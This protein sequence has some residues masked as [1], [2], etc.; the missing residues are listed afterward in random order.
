MKEL[1]INANVITV[2]DDNPRAEAFV[3]EDGMFVFVGS[4]E[5]AEN[6]AG[7]DCRVTD[8]KGLT[9]VPGFNDS[10]MHLLN[11]A[12]HR[13]K[14]NLYGTSS[15]DEIIDI[16][17]RWINERKP[18]DGQWILAAGWN[19]YD[20]K[21]G[22]ML[23][24][25]D[26]DKICSDKPMLFTRCCE[27][28]V[29]VN[30]KAMEI[31]G[32]TDETPDPESGIIERDEEGHATGILKEG[33]RYLAYGQ[34]PDKSVEE[35]KEMLIDGMSYLSSCGVTSVQ[36]DDFETFSSKNWRN[37]IQAYK[38]L[39]AEGKMTVRVYEQCLLPEM[40][41]FNEFLQAGYKTG[42]G[43]DVFKIG[44][45]KLLC[46][47]SLGPRTSYLR[48]DYSDDPGNRGINVFEQDELNELCLTAHKNG[49][50]VVCHAIGDAT[51]DM[52]LTAFEYAQ[53]NCPIKDHRDGIIHVQ[54]SPKDI[55]DRMLKDNVISYVQPIFVNSDLHMADGRLGER[56]KDAYKFR[57]MNEI[58]LRV[59]LSSDCPVESCNPID[60][61][62]VA[63]T[64]KDL[65]GYPEGGWHTEEALTIEQ[66]IKGFTI[67]G[68]YAQF[69]ENIK[70]SIE[71]DKYADF[72]VLTKDITQV[73]PEDILTIKAA[74]TY[75]GGSCVYTLD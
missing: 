10:H 47:G 25:S 7:E 65:N 72:V 44:P 38:E 63:V 51:C 2:D 46:D 75:M 37:V 55:L 64:R 11:F 41:R 26:L 6:A 74:A 40:G 3:V 66:V 56:V 52:V 28:T 69:M 29:C 50:H 67:D 68:A 70:G 43:S 60:S 35:I 23:N 45:L 18:A 22:R 16:S 33:A 9:V 39:E 62:Y 30:S 71:Q 19:H 34:L 24:A 13:T 57:T 59:P 61:A 14:I 21:E 8:L 15:I 54:M 27:H 12:F 17:K 1:F 53:K 36:P 5:E 31:I 58:G 4:N 32:I 20:F 48:E 49:M 73:D 42:V